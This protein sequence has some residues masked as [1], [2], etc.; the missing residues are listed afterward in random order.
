MC[1]RMRMWKIETESDTVIQL[2]RH[3][4]IMNKGE[5]ERQR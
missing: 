1:M 4:K 3:T 2:L 5:K